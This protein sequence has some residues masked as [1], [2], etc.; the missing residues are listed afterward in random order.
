MSTKQYEMELEVGKRLFYSDESMFGIYSCKPVHYNRELI[1]NKYG[2]ISLQGT[3]RKLSEG[4]SYGVKFD[5]TY[6]H[7]KYGEFYKI[8]E[9]EAERLNSV[10]EQD[11]FLQAVIADNHFNSLK[12]AYPQEKLVDMILEDRVDVNKTKG[13]KVKTLAKIKAEV[14]RNA[15]VSRM[16]VELNKF[17]LPTTRLERILLHFGSVELALKAIDE[18]IY[19]LCAVKQFGFA[20]VDSSYLANGGSP[21]DI[22]RIRAC[23]DF[24]IKKDGQNGH[25]WCYRK[26]ILENAV[27]LL[28]IDHDIVK[29]SIDELA[30]SR[31]YFL[32]DTQI[33][34]KSFRSKEEQIYK[35]LKRIAN[36]YTA[37]KINDIKARIEDTERLQGFKFTDE[38]VETISKI[39]QEHGVSIINGGAGVGKTSIVK[40][41][42]AVMNTENYNC[43]TLSGKA[44]NILSKSNL[45]AST[46]HRMLKWLPK[47]NMFQYNEDNPLNYNLLV[48]DEF[49]MNSIDLILTVLKAVKSGTKVILVGDSSQLP[50][51]GLGSGDVLRDLLDTKVFPIYQLTKVMRQGASSGILEV[52]DMVKSGEQLVPYGSTGKIS[53][54]ELKD[55]TVI[56][57]TE[58]NQIAPDILQICKS[59]KSKIEKPEDLFDFQVIVPN[60]ERGDLSVRNLNLKLQ[61]IFNN[62][63]KPSLNRNGYSYMQGDKVISNGNSYDQMIFEDELQYQDYLALSDEES[64][65]IRLGNIYNGTLGYIYDVSIREKSVLVQFEDVDGLVVLEQGNGDMEKLDLAYAA[66]CHRMQGSGIKNIICAISYESFMLLSREM[67]YTMVSRASSRGLLLAESTAL[68]KAIETSISKDRRTF[69]ADIIKTN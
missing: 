28:Q 5:G 16:I 43:S 46:I 44:A 37:P 56:T 52:S 15:G 61:Q 23:I 14:V 69:L 33:A 25:T 53:Y 27:E 7:P 17:N 36:S 9:V 68:H 63:S 65:D 22:K 47:E 3:T 35:H 57:Y 60:K 58:K 59:Y 67:A 50:S 55:Q 39:S 51:I 2:N 48:L 6:S 30:D 10:T 64:M 1:R 41:I 34:F 42:I 11:K 29:D 66:T 20:L 24:L 12:K 18:D 4:E 32:N 45:N 31:K 19:N 49:S 26:E 8:I 38:Q 40:G 21:T 62:T 54:G 13:I